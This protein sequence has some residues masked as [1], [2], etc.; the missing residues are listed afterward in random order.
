MSCVFIDMC[1]SPL[2]GMSWPEATAVM[3]S[4][5]PEACLIQS[6]QSGPTALPLLA[7][8]SLYSRPAAYK[9]KVILSAEKLSVKQTYM[10]AMQ[11]LV[12]IVYPCIPCQKA[13]P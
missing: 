5:L 13:S 10:F 9:A 6:G 3:A 7:A 8:A 11:R 1:L 4:L 2:K 12:V